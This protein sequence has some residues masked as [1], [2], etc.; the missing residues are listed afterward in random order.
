[1][2]KAAGAFF[3]QPDTAHHVDEL[4]N[5]FEVRIR[6]K[7]REANLEQRCLDIIF[8]ESTPYREVF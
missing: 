6:F 5:H 4:F 8:L 7:E 2:A 3:A 1:M